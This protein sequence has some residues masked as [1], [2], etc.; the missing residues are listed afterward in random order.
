[1]RQVGL[2]QSL[3]LSGSE[4]PLCLGIRDA[5]PEKIAGAGFPTPLGPGIL[6]QLGT[7]CVHAGQH[8]GIAASF[9]LFSLNVSG[10]ASH[11]VRESLDVSVFMA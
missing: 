3:N 10:C 11:N 2:T 9:V 7:C 5:K 1:M 6:N 8:D 4:F